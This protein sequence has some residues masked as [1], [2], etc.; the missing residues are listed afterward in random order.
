VTGEWG[1]GED[2]ARWISMNWRSQMQKNK[3]LVEVV[4]STSKGKV[5]LGIMNT[6]QA[7]ALPD[8]IDAKVSHPDHKP[9]ETDVYIPLEELERHPVVTA[10]ERKSQ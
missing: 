2:G 8:E 1:T 10:T 6:E 9:G 4:V 3:P 7:L 5:P